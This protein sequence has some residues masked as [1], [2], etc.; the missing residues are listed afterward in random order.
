MFLKNT[1]GQHIGFCLVAQADGGGLAGLAPLAFV[2]QDGA[3]AVL[4]AGTIRDRGNGQY[5]YGPTQAETNCAEL[6]VILVGTLAVPMEKTV[7]PFDVTVPVLGIFVTQTPGGPNYGPEATLQVHNDDGLLWSL[8]SPGVVALRLQNAG[9]AQ[10]GTVNSGPQTFG[11]PKTFHDNVIIAPGTLGNF[12][13]LQ[14]GPTVPPNSGMVAT[15]QWVDATPSLELLITDAGGN[16]RCRLQLYTDTASAQCVLESQDGAGAN[17]FANYGVRDNTGTLVPG[18]W[19]TTGGLVFAGGLFAGGTVTIS[20]AAITGKPTTLAGYGITSPLD[21]AEGGTGLSVTGPDGNVLTALAGVWVS[22][23]PSGGGTSG[24]YTP[25]ATPGANV[26]GVSTYQ[27]QWLRVGN[28]VTVSGRV[29]VLPTAGGP[30]QHWTLSL[31]I[32]SAFTAP[33]NLGGA[34]VPTPA[35]S[36]N[37]QPCSIEADVATGTAAFDA[38]CTFG[39]L[40]SYYDFSF[41]YQ[42]I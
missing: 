28:M 24:T 1:A 31:P 35:T 3:A 8:V 9:P 16:H 11:G 39:G 19:A 36:A 42:V 13:A 2:V 21:V 38:L 6:S 4:G 25:T 41:A 27:C 26:T 20:W 14:L 23:P 30:P 33:E 22:A 10:T 40:N 5:D 7:Y 34:G 18:V 15:A 17:V 32:S 37:Q 12:P 29:A